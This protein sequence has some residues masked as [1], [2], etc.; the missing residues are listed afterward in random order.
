MKL[1]LQSK[2]LR[3]VKKSPGTQ[4]KTNSLLTKNHHLPIWHGLFL[5][6]MYKGQFTKHQFLSMLTQQFCCYV[7]MKE[8]FRRDGSVSTSAFIC[9]SEGY[10]FKKNN[11]CISQ[12]YP[13]SFSAYLVGLKI[14]IT[15]NLN[16]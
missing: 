1:K 7:F 6:S 5:P 2:L 13:L 9:C 8:I 4:D 3:W 10:Q 12:H 16:L 15:S 11:I 14:P